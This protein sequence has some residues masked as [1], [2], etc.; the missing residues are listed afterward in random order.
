MT[1]ASARVAESYGAKSEPSRPWMRS[2]C[3]RASTAPF[4]QA[5]MSASSPQAVD[6]PASASPRALVFFLQPNHL[7]H[8]KSENGGSFLV[9]HASVEDFL[10]DKRFFPFSSGQCHSLLSHRDIFSEQLHHDMIT[11]Q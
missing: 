2:C 11:A 8:A 6:S 1:M 3:L 9:G 10:H 7:S 4:A 5:G